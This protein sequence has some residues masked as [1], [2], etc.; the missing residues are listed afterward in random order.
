MWIITSR[1]IPSDLFLIP[2]RIGLYEKNTA[3]PAFSGLAVFL[4]TKGKQTVAFGC[5]SAGMVRGH[6]KENGQP[7][8]SGCPF[9]TFAGMC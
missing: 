5:R 1:R 6:G 7:F 2:F 3:K 4:L 9:C 8:C